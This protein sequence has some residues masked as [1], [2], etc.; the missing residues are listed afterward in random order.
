MARKKPATSEGVAPTSSAIPDLEDVS[1][2]LG[3]AVPEEDRPLLELAV[4]NAREAAQDY[5]GRP[6]EGSIPTDAAQGIRLLAVRMYAARD[7]SKPT[8]REIPLAV[9]YCWHGLRPASIA[10]R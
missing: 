9:R 8:A 7:A 2:F 4:R 6:L 10:V 5:A 1:A 3:G